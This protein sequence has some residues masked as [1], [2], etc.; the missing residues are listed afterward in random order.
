M[1]RIRRAV[2]D[3]LSEQEARGDRWAGSAKLRV[4]LSPEQDPRATVQ[5]MLP[6]ATVQTMLPWAGRSASQELGDL[7]CKMREETVF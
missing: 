5:T 7:V 6:W 2:H 3:T 4:T 1:V